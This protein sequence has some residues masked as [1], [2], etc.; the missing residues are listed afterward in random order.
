MRAGWYDVGWRNP[1]IK[2]PTLDELVAKEGAVL[3]RHYV[4]KYCSPT[5]RSLLSGRYPTHSGTA[6]N[7]NATMDLRFTSIATK[8]KGL[9]YATHMSGK[10]YSHS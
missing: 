4:Y 10:W 9:G 2:T 5:R 7:N 1:L 6:N 8:L 3:T